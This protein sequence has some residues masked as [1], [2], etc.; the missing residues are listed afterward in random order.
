MMAVAETVKL[1]RETPIG[2]IEFE[3]RPPAPSGYTY[4]RYHF[5]DLDGKRGQLPS[6][7]RVLGIFDKPGLTKW[8]IGLAA[9]GID[10]DAE[11]KR[12]QERGTDIHSLLE[13]FMVSGQEP[14]PAHHPEEH[15]G[16]IR[17]LNE[18]LLKYDPQPESV[19]Q[20]VAHPELG[21]AGRFDL[22]AKIRGL[23]TIVDL[24]TSDKGRV[25]R[26]AH[27]QAL[28]YAWAD[29]VCGAPP[30][31]AVL[32]VGI[33]RNGSLE[34]V[35]GCASRADWQAVIEVRDRLNRLERMIENPPSEVVE[36]AA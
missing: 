19:E 35:R 30:V 26:E 21:Y 25:Y 9:Q 1:R 31:E 27:L 33:G 10:P 3:E 15:R 5:T 6:V 4:R 34:C 22:R 24:K 14:I 11:A 17:G 2:L 8:K 36:V 18:F 7:S 13:T 20:L 16:W 29:E 23:S 12:A 28:A 32:I